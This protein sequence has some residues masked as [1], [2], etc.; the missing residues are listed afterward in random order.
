MLISNKSL[1]EGLAYLAGVDDDLKLI[2]QSD[3]PPPLWE[4]EPGFPSL[5]HI[6]LEQQVSL[7]SAQAAFDKLKEV[8]PELEPAPFL[9]LGDAALREIGF[10]RQKT[11]YVRSLA[12]SICNGTLSLPSL[13][14]QHEDAVRAQLTQVTGIGSWTADIYLLM[15][16]RRPDVW[17]IGDLALIKSVM[18]VKNLGEKPAADEMEKTAAAWRPWRSVAARILWN[19]Y[20][21][22]LNNRSVTS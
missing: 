5:V 12:E 1:L 16:L 9:S 18:H 8:L 6:I 10:S 13:S 21:I 19:H 22:R 4:R 2:I 11:R 17:P 14:S 20:I 15:A 3:G 7:A